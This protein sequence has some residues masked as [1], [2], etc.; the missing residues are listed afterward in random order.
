MTASRTRWGGLIGSN[1][2]K[3]GYFHVEFLDAVWWLIDPDGGR[4]LSKGVNTVCLAQDRIKGT[5]RI[6]YAEACLRKYKNEAAWR[7]AAA[8]RLLSLGFNTLGAWSDEAVGSAGP[9][10][11][12]LTPIIDLGATF[13]ARRQ[14]QG[15]PCEAF[16]DVFDPQFAPHVRKRAL[17]LC[18]LRQRDQ[19]II[20]WLTDNEL[21]WGA[22]WRGSDELLGIFMNWPPRRPGR[23]AAIAMLKRRYPDFGYFN[24]V[25]RTSCRSWEDLAHV[26]AVSA[27]YS[28]KPIYDRDPVAETWENTV[29]PRRSR[30]FADCEAFQQ[31]IAGIYFATTRAAIRTADPNHMVLG[32]RLAYVPDPQVLAQAARGS[33]IL[34]FNCYDSDPVKPIR[35]ADSVSKPLIL[36]EFSFRGDDA[37]LPNQFG[38]GPRV[39]KQ[40]DRAICFQRYVERALRNPA[41][42]GYHWFEHADQPAEGRFDGENSNYGIVTI[43]D[44]IYGDLMRAMTAVNSQAEQIHVGLAKL[45]A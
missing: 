36:T 22:D 13:G 33:D 6:P 27:P 17:E 1:Q 43:R 2:S 41:V 4:F 26:R 29:D 3:T 18:S 21:R 8:R 44:E 25:W 10:P 31:E 24:V 32:C 11:L 7:V 35:S 19:S 37:A 40:P 38:A 12:A 15:E 30:F 39:P 16:P 9:T 5:D 28:R 34:S 23:N 45:A 42:V 20:G 14:M